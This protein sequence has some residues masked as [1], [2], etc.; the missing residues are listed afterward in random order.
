[1]STYQIPN[2]SQQKSICNSWKMSN[3]RRNNNNS[4]LNQNYFQS[5]NLLVKSQALLTHQNNDYDT[6]NQQEPDVSRLLTSNKSKLQTVA[7]PTAITINGL[8]ASSGQSV[9]M[10]GF[11]SK[12]E[13]FD[14]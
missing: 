7:K 9:S 1:M 4:T 12:V 14:K 8:N 6:Q 2:S 10:K 13:Q 3:M 5:E 11:R